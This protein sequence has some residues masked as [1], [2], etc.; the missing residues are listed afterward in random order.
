MNTARWSTIAWGLV[1]WMLICLAGCTEESLSECGLG[2]EMVN[3]VCQAMSVCPDGY[4]LDS[5]GNCVKKSVGPNPDEDLPTDSDRSDTPTETPDSDED[6]IPVVTGQGTCADP[7]IMTGET[8]EFPELAST[9]PGGYLS[10]ING[11]RCISGTAGGVKAYGS[12]AIVRVSLTVG[13]TIDAEMYMANEDVLIYVLRNSCYDTSECLA[14]EDSGHDDFVEFLTFTAPETTDYYVVFDTH[15]TV[16]GEFTGRIERVQDADGDGD[17]ETAAALITKLEISIPDLLDAKGTNC[18][19]ADHP[20]RELAL[21]FRDYP[22]S[23]SFF[24]M[25]DA[26]YL[27]ATWNGAFLENWTA[28][29]SGLNAEQSCADP[30]NIVRDRDYNSGLEFKLYEQADG[31]SGLRRITGISN[32]GDVNSFTLPDLGITETSCLFSINLGVPKY[33]VCDRESIYIYEF[34]CTTPDPEKPEEKT[35]AQGRS[36]SVGNM[37]RN[38][39]GQELPDDTEL[40]SA[41]TDGSGRGDGISYTGKI[42]VLIDYPSLDQMYRISTVN[43]VPEILYSA[44]VDRDLVGLQY[45]REIEEQRFYGVTADSVDPKLVIF[46]KN[47]SIIK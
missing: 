38:Y 10:N 20:I 32:C 9:F 30:L 11:E 1:L 6:E 44:T 22:N 36:F 27:S 41:T 34:T 8:F 25:T 26:G 17:D 13:E 2:Q 39:T 4:V 24:F 43:T 29:A 5:T 21:S 47:S 31:I 12:E 7:Y 16:S 18:G 3:G 37:I 33:Y 45:H 23:D 46:T 14:Y 35:I 28:T 40:I 15:E 42:W 19:F